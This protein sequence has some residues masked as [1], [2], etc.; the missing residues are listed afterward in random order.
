MDTP[1][2]ELKKYDR[3]IFGGMAL[4]GL[5]DTKPIASNATADGR[6]QNRRVT[7]VLGTK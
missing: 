5:G 3:V 2:V 7:V 1:T 4:L 6:A